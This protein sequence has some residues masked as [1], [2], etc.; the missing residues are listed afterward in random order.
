[1]GTHI[2]PPRLGMGGKDACSRPRSVGR[3]ALGRGDDADNG[4]VSCGKLGRRRKSRMDAAI[5]PSPAGG[6]ARER[7]GALHEEGQEM[8]ARWG[9]RVWLWCVKAPL[10][11]ALLGWPDDGKVGEAGGRYREVVVGVAVVLA[12]R[13]VR[14]VPGRRVCRSGGRSTPWH[15][16]RDDLHFRGCWCCCD[17]G[18]RGATHPR[19]RR[20]QD[21]QGAPVPLAKDDVLPGSEEAGF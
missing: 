21:G 7:A 11:H 10:H 16:D 9:R 18:G 17:R 12:A 19:R 8:P 3:R 1:M 4:Q 13:E 15:G 2:H 6:T 14:D 5:L 20:R